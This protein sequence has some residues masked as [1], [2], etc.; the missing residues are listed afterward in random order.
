MIAETLRPEII[1][2]LAPLG[3]L[4]LGLAFTKAQR[5]AIINR[6][7]GVCQ[8]PFKHVCRGNEEIPEE[9]R[10]LQV[11]HILPQ[12]YCEVVGIENP[13]FAENG[14]TLCKPAHVGPNGI[15]PDIASARSQEDFKRIFVERNEKLKRREVYWDT[16]HDRQMHVLAVKNTQIAL[17]GGWVFPERR[18][19]TPKKKNDGT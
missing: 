14:L 10:V 3:L 12:R 16:S 2:T 8:A 18:K 19:Q 9:N 4:V 6:D 1:T 13:D 5:T 17:K 7:K 11:H 15:H